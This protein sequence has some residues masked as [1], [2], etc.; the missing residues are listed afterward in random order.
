MVETKILTVGGEEYKMK[1][2][3]LTTEAFER[4]TGKK[5]GH[6]LSRYQ[7]LSKAL[8]TLSAEDFEEYL[9]ENILDMQIDALQLAYCMIREADPDFATGMEDFMGSVGNLSSKELKGVL[10]LASSVFP[11]ALQQ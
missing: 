4:L 7:K 6:V 11:R 3:I 5:F 2:S 10:Q 1:C 8:N 9:V